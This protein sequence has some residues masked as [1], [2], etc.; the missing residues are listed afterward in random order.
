MAGEFEQLLPFMW[1]DVHLPLSKINVTLAHDLV[2]HKYWGVDGARV[3]STGAAAIR[4]S[5]V[6]PIANSIFP[7]KNEKW[8]AGALYPKAL[9]KFMLAFADKKTGTLQHPEFGLLYVK[10]EHMS[11]EL[12]GDKQDSTE[13]QASWVE[14]INED[15]RAS[16]FWG[17]DGSPVQNI[18]FGASDLNAS[19]VDL[20]ELAPGLP[21]FKDDLESLARKLSA[22]V[23]VVSVVSYRAAGVVN[24][25]L[26]QAHRLE[27]S[28]ERA[29]SGQMF[30][31]S[32]LRPFDKRFQQH[33]LTWPA[34]EALQKIKA[35]SYAMRNRLLQPGGI[36]LYAVP[37]DTTLAGVA[38]SLPAGTSMAD[39]IKLNPMLARSPVVSKGTVVRY[40]L[41]K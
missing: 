38:S 36:G 23:D 27:T 32:P 35:G 11:F 6:I 7:G 29:A 10:P 4:V 21:E 8:A 41:K 15:I 40:P 37:D 14:T 28:I 30:Q 12:T 24:R 1:R 25:I 17:V 3:E 26:Y 39:V 16:S 31:I 20:R 18:E 9:R 34:I 22:L 13:I 33:A 2:E 5:A 19:V